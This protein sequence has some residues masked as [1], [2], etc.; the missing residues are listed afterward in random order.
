MRERHYNNSVYREN[1]FTYFTENIHLINNYGVKLISC[2][3]YPLCFAFFAFS[4]IF[5]HFPGGMVC[6][7]LLVIILFCFHTFCPK[8]QVLPRISLIF[9][10][11]R[12]EVIFI[13]PTNCGG[14]ILPNP[15]CYFST[16]SPQ[17]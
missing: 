12:S 14:A 5:F 2:I 15:Q 13:T 9:V 11:L 8:R 3:G 17:S 1:G 7:I 16:H 4:F 6:V 10:M